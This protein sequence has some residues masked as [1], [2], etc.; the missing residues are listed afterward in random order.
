MVSR[1]AIRNCAEY[2][3][4]SPHGRIG[5]VADVRY[6]TGDGGT[7]AALVVRAGR[8]GRRLFVIPV[9][10]L[11][12]IRAAR[13]RVITCSSPVIVATEAAAQTTDRAA[14]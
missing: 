11:E 9:S 4:D 14:T 1:Q 3:V 10:E 13:R 6:E 8:N 5:T 12:T 2:V 7:P